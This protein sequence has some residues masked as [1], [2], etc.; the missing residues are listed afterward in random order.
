MA[1]RQHECLTMSVTVEFYGIPRQR[2]GVA[3]VEVDGSRLGDVLRQVAALQP[4]LAE[5]CIDGEQ[6]K[7]GYLANING[8][9]F[10]A[11]PATALQ[12]GDCVLLISADAGG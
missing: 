12:P 9:K 3:S 6:L 1:R 11:D 10:T 5:C 2:A 8:R 7:P 4:G